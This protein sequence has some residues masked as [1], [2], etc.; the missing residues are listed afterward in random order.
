MELSQSLG[1]SHTSGRP[2]GTPASGWDVTREPPEVVRPFRQ[3]VA[4]DYAVACEG[5]PSLSDH[6]T[7]QMN[8]LITDAGERLIG[9]YLIGT[10]NEA[11]FL[12]PCIR[13][14]T[15][16]RGRARLRLTVSAAHTQAPGDGCTQPVVEVDA[17]G[18]VERPVAEHLTQGAAG[19]AQHMVCRPV[20]VA[21]YQGVGAGL[22]QPG[23]RGVRI[24]PDV[25][26]TGQ[27]GGSGLLDSMLG[28][29][30]KEK[31][32]DKAA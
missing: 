14:P 23:E 4:M 24:V 1:G 5:Q 20:R 11:G 22:R 15:V 7:G 10:L 2:E 29:L 9:Q 31:T 21:V 13:F 27:A 17:E 30:V 16:A 25:S 28:L 12:I 26:V 19:S 3:H 18:V 8:L 6:L 32:H